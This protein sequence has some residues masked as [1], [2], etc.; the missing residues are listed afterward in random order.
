MRVRDR[1]LIQGRG[2]V[3]IAEMD[4]FDLG[5]GYDLKP[6]TV[7]KRRSDGQTWAIL[8]IRPGGPDPRFN[9][10]A[11]LLPLTPPIKVGDEIE[12]MKE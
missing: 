2:Q 10:V 5:G 3:I 4:A 11:I 7:V 9:G 8:S 1:Q 12:R 6:K